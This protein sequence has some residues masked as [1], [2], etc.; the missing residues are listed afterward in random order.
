MSTWQVITW[1]VARAGGMTAYILIT[2]SVVAG[3]A[4]TLQFQS[5]RW[6]RII[7]NEL[8]NFLALLAAIFVGIHILAVA[9]DPFTNFGLGDLLV[10][11]VSTYR[12][13]WMAM[14]IVALYLGLAIGLSTLIRPKIGY[15]LWRK[16]HI[17]TFAI[18]LLVTAH[19]IFTGS[20]ARTWWATAIY[21]AS[22]GIVGALIA[23]RLSNRPHSAP[24]KQPEA[25]LARPVPSGYSR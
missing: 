2:L 14:G 1:D 10:P 25:Q 23:L 19:G 24:R 11:F 3:L 7:N 5:M 13:I 15:A 18:Y 8:H 22:V 12:P 4:M 17:L 16:L 21:L 9:L 6:P 20:D